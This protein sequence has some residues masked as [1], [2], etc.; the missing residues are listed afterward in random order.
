MK[1]VHFFYL[2]AWVIFIP[3]ACKRD[4]NP[5]PAPE[6]ETVL[7]KIYKNGVLYMEYSYDANMKAI[8]RINTY[9]SDGQLQNAVE[10]AYD[11]N[12]LLGSYTNY[13]DSGEPTTK[14]LFTKDENGHFQEGELVSLSGANTGQVVNRHKYSYNADGLINREAWLSLSTGAEKSA[15]EYTYYPNGNL[16]A[17]HYYEKLQPMAMLSHKAEFSPAGSPLPETIA[18]HKG[19]PINFLIYEFVAEKIHYTIYDNSGSGDDTE[20]AYH[21]TDREYNEQGFVISQNNTLF[22]PPPPPSEILT[23]GVKTTY[24][25]EYI[26]L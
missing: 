22:D 3:G 2:M 12:G 7:S 13:D 26:E 23:I 11:S 18:K 19:Y 8:N 9:K 10:F 1:L 6:K 21:F 4:H 14:M 20:Y 16:K 24:R 15:R 25:Y 17:Y 5:S